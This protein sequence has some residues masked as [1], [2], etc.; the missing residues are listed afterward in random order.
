MHTRNWLFWVIL[1]ISPVISHTVLSQYTMNSPYSRFGVG[2]ME[3][4]GFTQNRSM[5]GIGVGLRLPNQINI[6][7][8]AAATAQD[9]LSF[10][11][12]VGM[13]GA[14][15]TYRNNVA[16][17]NQ[18]NFNFDHL[19]FSASVSNRIAF[20]AG[21]VPYSKTGYNYKEIYTFPDNERMQTEYIGN[22]NINRFYVG[23]GYAFFKKKISVGYQL[24]YLF[25]SITQTRNTIMIDS[26]NKTYGYYTDNYIDFSATGFLH[27]FGIQAVVPVSSQD[28]LV[29]GLVYDPATRLSSDRTITL[30]RGNDTLSYAGDT[31]YF[32]IPSRIGIGAGLIVG[33]R[34]VLGMDYTWQDW[35]KATI[36]NQGDSLR[37]YS[38]LSVGAEYVHNRESYTS[39]LAKVRFRI[40]AHYENTYVQLNQKGIV[41]YGVSVGIALPMR[42]SNTFF[43]IGFEMGRRG[44][45][46]NNLIEDNYKRVFISLSLYDYWFFKRKYD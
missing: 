9:S 33:N 38:R 19:A 2:D 24:S 12:D 46:S 20:G 30:S 18:K 31:G 22:G 37:R 44:T 32:K 5:G 11:W 3:F 41:D 36:F 15:T 34:L 26:K 16:K 8:P 42:R 23:A 45:T 4:Q 25:G 7:N 43:H 28:L 14:L 39:Y 21:L 1:L 40:G 17:V 6:L 35:N 29:L 10:V 27:T 13:K